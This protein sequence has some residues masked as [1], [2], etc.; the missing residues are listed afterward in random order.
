MGRS[1]PHLFDPTPLDTSY[2]CLRPSSA[3]YFFECLFRLPSRTIQ[4]RLDSLTPFAQLSQAHF[5]SMGSQMVP[6]GAGSSEHGLMIK[7][8]RCWTSPSATLI[9]YL[10]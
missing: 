9:G 3:F 8:D 10:A 1:R 4:L 7:R 6:H 5:R 2:A